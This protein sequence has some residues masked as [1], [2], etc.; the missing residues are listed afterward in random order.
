[1]EKRPREEKFFWYST[2]NVEPN[3]MEVLF[4]AL[5]ICKNTE[6]VAGTQEWA[7]K[8]SSYLAFAEALNVQWQPPEAEWPL[9]NKSSTLFLPMESAFKNQQQVYGW[10]LAA[11]EFSTSGAA[12]A[13]SSGRPRRARCADAG[14]PMT[15]DEA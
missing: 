8:V 3:E 15:D 10:R 11:S 2:G 13:G 9:Y 12:A 14:D 5:L 6:S 7:R 1:M 4:Y